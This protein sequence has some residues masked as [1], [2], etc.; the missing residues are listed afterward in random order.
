MNS[1]S[2]FHSNYKLRLRTKNEKRIF[3]VINVFLLT[4]VALVVSALF[5]LLF[6][7]DESDRIINKAIVPII[8]GLLLVISY[9]IGLDSIK[10]KSIS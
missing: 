5:Y 9:F 1:L 6:N 2:T 4:G 3:F 8:T 10:R 7:L